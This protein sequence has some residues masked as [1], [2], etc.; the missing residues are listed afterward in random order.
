M[1]TAFSEKIRGRGAREQYAGWGV[2]E[3]PPSS[4]RMIGLHRRKPPMEVRTQSRV[5]CLG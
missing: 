2:V 5:L 3:L 4:R 1:K